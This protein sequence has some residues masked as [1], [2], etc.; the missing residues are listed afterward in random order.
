MD[1]SNSSTDSDSPVGNIITQSV[2]CDA[3]VYVVGFLLLSVPC[4]QCHTIRL[5]DLCVCGFSWVGAV[6]CLLCLYSNVVAIRVI[7]NV[8]VSRQSILRSWLIR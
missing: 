3:D 6:S 5:F 8:F 4:C 2:I 1:Y 7:K